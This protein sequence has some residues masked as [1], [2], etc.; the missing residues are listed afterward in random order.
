MEPANTMPQ[1]QISHPSDIS[2]CHHTATML[3]PPSRTSRSS[4]RK[5]LLSLNSFVCFVAHITSR[6]IYFYISEFLF[7]YFG[8]IR[9]TTQFACH[10]SKG[11]PGK[12]RGGGSI[13]FGPDC[14]FGKTILL[15]ITWT[16]IITLSPVSTKTG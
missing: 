16:D 6:T 10:L 7:G 5:L 3:K 11:T 1:V 14:E 12:W 8:M 9:A 13:L 2:C 4:K 15:H